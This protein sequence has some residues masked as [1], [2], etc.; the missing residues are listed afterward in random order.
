[1]KSVLCSKHK[2][3][4]LH[5]FFPFISVLLALYRITWYLPYFSYVF[6]FFLLCFIFGMEFC[7][8]NSSHK[9]RREQ[10]IVR[11]K[12]WQNF[13]P[14]FRVFL[15]TRRSHRKTRWKYRDL[16]KFDRIGP[17]YTSNP[18]DRTQRKQL[19]RAFLR[20]EKRPAG[21]GYLKIQYFRARKRNGYDRILGLKNCS[22]A[23]NNEFISVVAINSAAGWN[24]LALF[25][26][27]AAGSSQ[28]NKYII[29]RYVPCFGNGRNE[30]RKTSFQGNTRIIDPLVVY[31]PVDI[32][33]VRI[34]TCVRVF[35]TWKYYR[36]LSTRLLVDSESNG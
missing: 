11:I 5:F 34:K 27:D 30:R 13:H 14:K 4:I 35:A 18:Q 8:I 31:L 15:S 17:L 2:R 22:W 29:R 25:H 32:Y 28:W 16:S 7:Q 24:N 20:N 33:H 3:W 1:M 12:Q 26:L 10:R 36:V 23:W 21:K 19:V 9:I 6:V